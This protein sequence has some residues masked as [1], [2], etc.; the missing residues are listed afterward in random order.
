MSTEYEYDR[1]LVR[2][3]GDLW[4]TV[5]NVVVTSK[6]RNVTKAIKQSIDDEGYAIVK[7][8]DDAYYIYVG[9]MDVDSLTAAVVKLYGQPEDDDG[10]E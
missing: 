2:R 3:N 8:S 1:A 6:Q 9:R 4:E 10:N 5:D 7:E